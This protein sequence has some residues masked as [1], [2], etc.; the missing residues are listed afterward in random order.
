MPA[1]DNSK[2]QSMPAY[3]CNRPSYVE[4]HFMENDHYSENLK[5]SYFGFSRRVSSPETISLEP[6]SYPSVKLSADDLELL[7]S[8]SSV[9]SSQSPEETEARSGIQDHGLQQQQQQQVDQ[10]EDE[11]EVMSSYVIEINSDYREGTCDAV[12]IDEAIAWVK[13]K[14]Q[15]QSSEED[16]SLR[17]Q[18]NNDQSV[19]LETEGGDCN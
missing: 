18:D 15:K 1:E 14:F 5:S 9:V 19:E 2:K 4:N 3:H 17:Q 16:L 13:E 10:D 6:N 8:P 12:G 11:D 7:N